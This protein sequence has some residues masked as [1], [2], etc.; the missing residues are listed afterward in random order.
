[1]W[2]R[3]G[4]LF[5]SLLMISAC[6]SK[7]HAV[8]SGYHSYNLEKVSSAVEQLEFQPDLPEYIP[9]PMISVVSDIYQDD[10]SELMDLSFYTPDND[11]LTIQFSQEEIDTPWMDPEELPINDDIDGVYED[12]RF[13][14]KLTWEKDGVT[15]LMTYRTSVAPEEGNE[16]SVTRQQLVE[17]ARSFH[18]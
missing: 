14:K 16:Q 3:F 8:P 6:G 15:Y 1:M 11:L 9:V 2:R 4:V 18:S 5:F 17:V 12:N 10:G 7:T 13:S